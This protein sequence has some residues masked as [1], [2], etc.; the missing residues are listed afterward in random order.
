M[1]LWQEHERACADGPFYLSAR[2]AGNLVDVND[3]KASR[4]LR[5]LRRDGMLRLVSEGSQKQRRASR[6]RYVGE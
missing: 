2:T 6:Y 5:G 4:W 1:A 3:V